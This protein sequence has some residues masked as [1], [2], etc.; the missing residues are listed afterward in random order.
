MAFGRT[1]LRDVFDHSLTRV[2]FGQSEATLERDAQIV[3]ASDEFVPG[4]LTHSRGGLDEDKWRRVGDRH[5]DI[6]LKF[7]GGLGF[8]SYQHHAQALGDRPL[9]KVVEWGCGG[10][11]NARVF[12]P[13]AQEFVGV[14]VNRDATIESGRV[15]R[16]VAPD[17]TYTPVVATYSEPEA[18]VAEIGS[19]TVDLY[20]SFYVLELVATEAY[21][22]RLMRISYDLVAPGGAAV[23]QIKYADGSWRNRTRGRRYTKSTAAS[24]VQF[25]VI[26]FDAAVREI[27][28]VP[29]LVKVVPQ[30]ELDQRYAYFLLTKP[31]H[32]GE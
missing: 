2:G 13:H 23:V 16:E 22:L 17:T 15:V 7:A 9:G 10:G 18:A 28:W 4:D 32:L 25:P 11:A 5:W 31:T 20:L 1:F 14:D 8:D 12:A 19:G 24:M 29:E 26:E 3:W 21:A 6:Y 30:D 27:G